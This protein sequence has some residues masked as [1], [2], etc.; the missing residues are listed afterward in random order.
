MNVRTLERCLYK[1]IN[2]EMSNVVDM[3]EDIIQNAI[4]TTSDNMVTPRIKLAVRSINASP[5]RDA[6]SFT[7]ISEQGERAEITA[8]FGN[9]SE[10]N[11][12]FHEI[13]ANG[14]NGGNIPDKVSEFSVPRTHFDW[15]LHTHHNLFIPRLSMFL[16]NALKSKKS[17][18]LLKWKQSQG[19]EHKISVIKLSSV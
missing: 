3:V 9:V 19:I 18:T 2:R 10:R 1:R 8:P 12:T 16:P 11:N 15:Q 14:K 4:L 7:A 13:N 6:T 17:I 5:G